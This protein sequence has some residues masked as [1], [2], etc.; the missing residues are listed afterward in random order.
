[1]NIIEKYDAY[2]IYTGVLVN[3]F[4]AYQFLDIWL[5]PDWDQASQLK[6]MAILMS[7]EFIMIHSGLMMAVS[8]KKIS[9]FIVFPFYGI[10]VYTYSQVTDDWHIIAYTYLFAVFNRMRFAFADVPE[11]FKKRNI[12]ISVFAGVTYIIVAIILT[13]Q[14]KFIPDFGLTQGYLEASGYFENLNINGTLLELPKVAICLGFLYYCILS[15]LEF[16]LVWNR[17]RFFK[18]IK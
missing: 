15:I 5:Y 4:I 8:S 2:F 11:N 9:L 3:A 12:F 18:P 6:S 16:Y 10:F 7:F 14:E 1:M 17:D 13:T